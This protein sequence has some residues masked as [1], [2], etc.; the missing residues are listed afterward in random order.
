MMPGYPSPPLIVPQ[1]GLPF[2]SLETLFD[3]MCRFG[4]PGEFLQR[5]VGVRIRQIVIMLVDVICLTLSCH[6]QHFVRTRSTGVGP[7]L[8]PALHGFDHQRPFLPVS[9]VDSRP[10]IFGQLLTPFVH[11]Y[12]RI[13]GMRAP[14]RVFWGRHIQVANQCVRGDR[15]EVSLAEFTQFQAKT[16]GTAHF[17]IARDP[18]VRQVPSAFRQHLQ[19]QLMAGAKLDRLG[20][21]GF[22][23]TAA[24]VGPVDVIGNK[25]YNGR[26]V[27]YETTTGRPPTV[28]GPHRPDAPG[29]STSADVPFHGLISDS[30]PQAKPA[31][32]QPRQRSAGGGSQGALASARRSTLVYP[33]LP[34]DLSPSSRHGRTL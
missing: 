22:L 12:E 28:S 20:H 32:G 19:C 30:I 10:G 14:S 15:Q 24:V 13:L 9:H 5:H 26:M 33:G 34:Q 2:G 21:T 8:D 1:A 16:R 3:A 31:E 4:H 25:E 23:A 11:S 7:C 18:G 17:V 6:K 29:V 27:T